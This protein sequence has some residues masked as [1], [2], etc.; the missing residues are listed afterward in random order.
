MGAKEPNEC[1]AWWSHCITVDLVGS[2]VIHTYGLP[3]TGVSMEITVS[4]LDIAFVDVC[5]TFFHL[6][7]HRIYRFRS[8]VVGDAMQEEIEIEGR[9]LRIGKTVAVVNVKFRRK[10]TARIFAQARHTKYLP[11][12]TRM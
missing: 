2:A 11:P 6:H 3:S 8:V 12:Q 5:R 1:V 10:K 9:A 4:Y 7:R